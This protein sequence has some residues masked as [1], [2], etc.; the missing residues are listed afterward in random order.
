MTDLSPQELAAYLAALF[1]RRAC[2]P[3]QVLGDYQLGH[4]G[5]SDAARVTRHLR[6]G[7]P[8]CRHELAQMV[9]FLGELAPTANLSPAEATLDRVRVTV[10]RLVS[11]AGDLLRP[12]LPGWEPACAGVRGGEEEPAI[13]EAGESQVIVDHPPD[14]AAPDRDT[15]IGLAAGV[16]PEGVIVYVWLGGE[17]IAAAPLEEGGN[18]VIPGMDRGRYELLLADPDRIIYIEELTL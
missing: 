13:Y 11:G 14:P 9:L 17:L 1:R 4:L 18:F 2:P 5:R 7:C 10:A 12:A 3:P 16:D 8:H 15:L 6:E